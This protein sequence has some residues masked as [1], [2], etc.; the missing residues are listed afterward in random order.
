VRVLLSALA[1]SALACSSS[2]PPPPPPA[3]PAPPPPS[4]E[5]L[6]KEAL[7]L[8]AEGELAAARAK[9]EAA[10]AASPRADPVR[11]EL[12]D[13]LLADGDELDR[14]A[15]VLAGADAAAAG[16]RFHLLSGRLA[17]LQAD[18][19]RAAVAYAR[20]LELGADPELR[21]Q[22][23]LVLERLGEGEAALAEL[24]ALRAL[25]PGAPGL[26][27]ALADRYEAAGR[28]AEAEAEL[29]RAAE[30]APGRAAGWD[31]LARFRARHGREDEAR[32]AAE[33]AR[34][35]ESK[36]DR[37]LRPLLPSRR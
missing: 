26:A 1:L 36:P 35:L 6:L 22:R 11:N 12:A 10:L 32:A 37:A 8:R 18:D 21:F 30:A 24:E 31:R 29:V 17:E 23:A 13:L 9:L 3:P 19:A 4:P 16:P 28:L 7:S 25:R 20:A 15:E 33:R 27:L 2:R 34:E 5:L 14:A